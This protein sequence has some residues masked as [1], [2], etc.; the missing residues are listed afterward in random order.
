MPA[1]IKRLKVIG[2][3][4]KSFAKKLVGLEILALG[5]WAT[6]LFWKNLKKPSKGS[7]SHIINASSLT[8]TV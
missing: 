3:A 2:G 5:F 1:L 7:S 8:P 4:M 6:K